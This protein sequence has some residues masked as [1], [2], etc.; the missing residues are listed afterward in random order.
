M[1]KTEE[2]TAFGD[3]QTPEPLA[4]AVCGVLQRRGQS[5]ASVVEP[6]CGQGSLLLA[7]L[8]GFPAVTSALGLDVNP[9]H[10]AGLQTRLDERAGGPPVKLLH[11]NFFTTDWDSLLAGLPEPL[12]VIGNPPWVTNAGLGSLGSDNLPRKS[13]FQHHVGLDAVTGKSNFDISEWML[14]RLLDALNGRCGTLAMLCKT[15][16]ARKLLLHAWNRDVQLGGAVLYEIDAVRHFGAS[17]AACLLV[18]DLQRGGQAKSAAVFPGLDARQ[19]VATWGWRGGRVV[20][21]VEAFDGCSH[22]AADGT[23]G[24][25][26]WR[27][28]VK[29]DCSRV[30]ELQAVE[31]GWRNKLGDVVGLESTYLYPLLKSSDIAAG[32]TDRP[33]NWLLVTQTAVNSPTEVIRERAPQTWAYLCQHADLLQGRRSSIY[34]NR[35]RFSVFGVGDYTFAP[36]KVAISSLYKK[37]AF[38]V[39]GGYQ[40]RP[41]VFDD[42][43]VFLACQSREEAERVAGLLNSESAR[44]FYSSLVFWDSKRPLTVDVLRR[45]DLHKL[46]VHGG[47]GREFEQVRESHG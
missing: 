29:H 23:G 21:D 42:T 30:M 44:E 35:P 32:R 46:A 18:C 5:P 15:A 20:A 39:V 27:S 28:G 3:F 43:V 37:L 40:G 1:G 6:T 25:Y 33:A 7:A 45:L 41:V 2:R 9:A 31:G 26:V 24:P 47:R 4:A 34:R 8:D 19:P 22:L 17:V 12:L 14:I 16:V 38:Q 10:L 11:D 36:Y 13:N